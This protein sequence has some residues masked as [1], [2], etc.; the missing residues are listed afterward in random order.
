MLKKFE[1]DFLAADLA[2][3]EA[4]LASHREAGSPVGIFQYTCRKAALE[5]EVQRISSRPDL[6]AELG[7]F[8]GGTPVKGARGIN[9]D[10]AVKALDDL[11]LLIA[12]KYARTAAAPL[13]QS[14]HVAFSD[15]SSALLTDVVSGSIGFVLEETVDPTRTTA[16]PLSVVVRK[17]ADILAGM[18]A[19][20]AAIFDDAVAAL[21][22]RELVTLRQ[23]FIR[24]DEHEATVRIVCGACDASLDARAV[25]L[26]RQRLQNTE[27]EE[28][29][30][31][32]V[33]TLYLLPES[34][35][36]ELQ[37]MVEGSPVTLSGT[38]ADEAAAQFARFSIDA[39]SVSQHRLTVVINTKV[40]KERSKPPRRLDCLVRVLSTSAMALEA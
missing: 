25:A 36:F 13:E 3:V 4:L 7:I 15:R 2:A 12:E 40:V 8:F 34:R 24:L 6:H 21:D 32:Y 30:A 33:G 22:Q 28:T 18:G 14:G 10:F 19:D 20:E 29:S 5:E 37:T 31:D 26:A 9:A 35:Q 38:V 11:Q 17:L 16:T 1:L 27:I 39:R 23:F